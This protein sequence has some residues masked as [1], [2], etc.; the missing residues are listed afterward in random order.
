[1]MEGK[2]SSREPGADMAKA[3]QLMDIEESGE[4][5]F[6]D[7]KRVAAQL[8]ESVTDEDI[9]T[10]LELATGTPDGTVSLPE[11]IAVI[12]KVTGGDD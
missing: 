2:M 12:T 1:M 10:M 6:K 8:G 9:R 5:T 4:L 3:F 11:F 7:L